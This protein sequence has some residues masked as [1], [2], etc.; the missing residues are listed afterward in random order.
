MLD[1]ELKCSCFYTSKTWACSNLT[2][3][4]NHGGDKSSLFCLS[5]RVTEKKVNNGDTNVAKMKIH[6]VMK[7][8]QSSSY[9][10]LLDIRLNALE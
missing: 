7:V 8:T 9:L 3:L 2:P 1:K 4:V 6:A 5:R 10:T